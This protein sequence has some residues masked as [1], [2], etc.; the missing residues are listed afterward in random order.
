MIARKS[1]RPNSY[2]AGMLAMADRL[3]TE[4]DAL[5]AGTVF[6]AIGAARAEVR[7]QGEV[8]PSPERIEALARMRLAESVRPVAPGRPQRR[9]VPSVAEAVR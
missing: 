1:R 4:F 3:F 9:R 6:R 2:E 5:P 8:M 7:E